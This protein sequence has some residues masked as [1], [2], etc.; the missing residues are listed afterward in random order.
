[1][2]KSIKIELPKS[3]ADTLTEAAQEVQY[4]FHFIG[5][6][7]GLLEGGMACGFIDNEKDTG[8]L[9]ALFSLL[10]RAMEHAA[11]NEGESLAKFGRLLDTEIKNV[12]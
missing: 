6:A 8:A 1:M 12:A 9:I 5:K 2:S 10:A 7:L 4:V 11:G 3:D